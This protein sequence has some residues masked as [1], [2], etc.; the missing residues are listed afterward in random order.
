M[1]GPK[2]HAGLPGLPGM[3]GA[4]GRQGERG[5]PGAMG[6]P[7]KDGEAGPRGMVPIL[8]THFYRRGGHF[9]CLGDEKIRKRR[10]GNR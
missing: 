4:P 7:G 9:P 6:P 10:L 8:L 2:G 1:D 3:V 5:L